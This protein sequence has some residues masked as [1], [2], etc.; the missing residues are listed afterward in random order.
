MTIAIIGGAGF[1]GSNLTRHL[2]AQGQNVRIIDL[3]PSQEFPEISVV[4]D[5][6]DSQSLISALSGA[7]V[8]YHLAAEH[9]DDVKPV[10]RYYDVN[11][12][13]GR[14]VIA[15]ARALGIRT[16]IFTS[17]VALY[18]LDKP[19]SQETDQ[20]E[21]FNDYGRSKWQ[22]EQDFQ[23][24]AQEDPRHSARI[25]RL[26]AT[27]GAG[28]RGNIYTLMEQIARNRFVM[29]GS[30][31]NKKSIAY[32]ENVAAFLDFVRT[33]VTGSCLYN[34]AD[35]PDLE[36][37]ELVRIIRQALGRQGNPFCVP[38]VMGLAGGM[39]FDVLSAVTRK[40][41]PMSAVRVRKFCANTLVNADR[42]LRAGFVAPI[43]LQQGLTNMIKAEFKA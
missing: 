23:N 12:E 19:Q 31:K 27:F 2:I 36:M 14:N 8:I 15:A 30:G 39:V 6:C 32:V 5:V 43:S 33:H 34:Y 25:I 18:G 7:E 17:S 35:K 24:W 26:V 38:Y 21:P 42:A 4:C 20:P 16:I 10:Q 22:S 11:V 3:R 40:S 37:I 9:R 29:V 1:I 13:G 41:F 28:N